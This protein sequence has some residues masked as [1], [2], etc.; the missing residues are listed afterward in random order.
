MADHSIVIYPCRS[1][2]TVDYFK[3]SLSP[4]NDRPLRCTRAA[5]LFS[6]QNNRAIRA[7]TAVST[8]RM[9]SPICIG[10]NP[11]ATSFSIS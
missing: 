8:L 7:G 2:T 5:T 10:V 4:A 6:D 9:R 3:R 11:H 1:A